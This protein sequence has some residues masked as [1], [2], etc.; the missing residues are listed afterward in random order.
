MKQLRPY[1]FIIGLSLY[2]FMISR[3][4]LHA[5]WDRLKTLDWKLFLLALL[6]GVPEVL[7]KSLRLKSFVTKSGSHISLKK[8]VISFMSGQPL[9]AVTPG[10]LG[11]VTRIVLLSRYG[12]ISTPTALAVHVADRLYDLAAIVLLAVIGL[13]SFLT[14]SQVQGPALAT[15]I[16]ILAGMF[17]ILVLLNPRWMKYVLNPLMS[18]ILSK[19]MADQLSHHTKEFYNKLHALLVPSFSLFGPFG[20]SFLAWETAIFRNCVLALALGLPLSYLKFVLLVPVMV[21]V[22]LLPISI[23]GFGPREAALFMLFT[24]PTLHQEDLAVFS[25]L[26]VVAGPIFISLMGIPASFLILRKHP[27]SHEPA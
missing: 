15:V 1:A 7:F 2:V 8:S 27:E 10:K 26:M 9:A 21:V 22:E 23:L 6:I 19:K 13:V 18:G 4:D 11:D 24:T 20:L 25:L 12:R 16:G 3:L 17:L 14:Q 5:S